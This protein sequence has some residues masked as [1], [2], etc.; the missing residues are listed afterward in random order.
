MTQSSCKIL[1]LKIISPNSA[2]KDY[3]PKFTQKSNLAIFGIKFSMR[4]LLV[5]EIVVIK[6]RNRDNGPGLVS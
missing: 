5:R 4:Q 2:A 1:L 6:A 3:K